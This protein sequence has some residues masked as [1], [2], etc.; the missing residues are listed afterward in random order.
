[1]TDDVTQVNRSP[2]PQLHSDLH[3]ITKTSPQEVT[4]HTLFIKINIRQTQCQ[5]KEDV[6]SS[7]GGASFDP[8]LLVLDGD[9]EAFLQQ[10]ELAD[11]V[12]DGVCERFLSKNTLIIRDMTSLPVKIK[13]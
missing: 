5:D 4:S 11:E 8:F 13:Q 10:R 9:S 1:M 12:S 2:V 3:Y 6:T 7:G